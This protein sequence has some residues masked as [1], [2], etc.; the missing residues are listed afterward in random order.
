M[1]SFKCAALKK[2]KRSPHFDTM[3]DQ[4]VAQTGAEPTRQPSDGQL[5]NVTTDDDVGVTAEAQRVANELEF[6]VVAGGPL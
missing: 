4:H 5:G 6:T 1:G 2:T 3:S